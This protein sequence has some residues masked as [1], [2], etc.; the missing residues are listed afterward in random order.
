MAAIGGVFSLVDTRNDTDA[1]VRMSRAMLPRGGSEREAYISESIGMFFGRGCDST[2]SP[3]AV[4]TVGSVGADGRSNSEFMLLC[5]GEIFT[6]DEKSG[7][8]ARFFGESDAAIA[9]EGFMRYG[10]EMGEHFSGEFAIAAY[11]GRRKEL[12]LLRDSSGGRP[13]YYLREGDRIAFASEIK[14]L[15]A[16]M[17][18]PAAISRENLCR[19]VFSSC[20]Q[21]GGCDIY[22]DIF[23]VERGGG[24]VC[25]RISTVPFFYKSMERTHR[26]VYPRT[27]GGDFVCPD[28]DG[29]NRL[30][31]EIL[32]VFDY[33]Q[34]DHLMPS[35]LRDLRMAKDIG[36]T[37]AVSD[38]SLCMDIPYSTQRRDRL[39]VMAG[40]RVPCVPP[41]RV[42]VRERGLKKMER[43]LKNILLET[44]RGELCY[45]FGDDW[46]RQIS[47]I[48]NA[49]RRIRAMGMMAQ[50]GVFLRSYRLDRNV[51]Y[52]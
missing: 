20:G 16:F 8:R 41:S 21:L 52:K 30:L 23:E 38:G 24:C 29:L 33:P 5:D 15:L 28:E 48:G 7:E 44:D 42:T 51:A 13:L 45:I 37:V 6:G 1:L 27:V 35:F 18:S 9:L 36:G 10:G 50:A 39:S 12:L 40:A 25:S 26:D 49:E 46:E 19:H 11:D 47:E 2:E 32:F 3:M 31:T 4:N 22:R 43:V 14:G 17:E 34:F